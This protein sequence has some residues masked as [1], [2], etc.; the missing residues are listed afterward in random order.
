MVY[1]GGISIAL[2]I[3][4]LLF[5]KKNKSAADRIFVAWMGIIILN[6]LLFYLTHTKVIYEYP[7]LLGLDFPL[8]LLMGV[9]LY[10]YVGSVTQQ[11]PKKKWVLALHFIPILAVYVYM[12]H[13][14]MLPA[15]DKI[16]V[17]EHD[18]KGYETFMQI[19]SVSISVSGVVY[20]IWSSMLLKQHK[21][22]IEARF[23]NLDKVNLR[24]LQQLVY[25]IGAIW[26]IVVFSEGVTVVFSAVVVFVF[27][28]G[29]NGVRQER[30][31]KANDEVNSSK[32]IET[33]LQ[34]QKKYAKSGLK[35]EVSQQLYQDLKLLMDEQGLYKNRELSIGDLASQLKVHPNHLSQVINV[36]EEKNFYDF[37]NGYRV[38]EFKRLLEKPENK[39]ITLLALAYDCGFN[40]KSSFNRYFKKTTGQTPSQF[41]AK[42][43]IE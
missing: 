3:I 29:F 36:K 15:E 11:L 10:F 24:W 14:F 19:L 32:G 7:F 41:Y 17:F 27:L 2:F 13:F 31:F 12:F 42:V 1:I 38:E 26:V 33:E 8:P 37:V 22:R 35:E 43:V 34:S 30:I 28:I 23:S 18:G 39:N 20:V 40:S 6:L 4:F 16:Y 21:R 25:G 5:S 9:M